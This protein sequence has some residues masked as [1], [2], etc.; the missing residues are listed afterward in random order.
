MSV[1]HYIVFKLG[2]ESYAIES[3]KIKEIERIKDISMNKVPLTPKFIKGIINLRGDIVP[4]IHLKERF[5]L[6]SDSEDCPQK[7][8]VVYSKQAYFGLLVDFIEGHRQVESSETLP[9]TDVMAVD[10]P[11]IKAIVKK[12]HETYFVLDLDRLF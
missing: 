9:P 11:Y 12:E 10:T 8:I 6:T 2:D 7:L 4:I 1:E 5:G 3:N